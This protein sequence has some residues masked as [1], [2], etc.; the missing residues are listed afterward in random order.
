MYGRP[1]K[2]SP[3]LDDT[4]DEIRGALFLNKA[5]RA[6]MFR[7][8]IA[9]LSIAYKSHKNGKYLGVIDPKNKTQERILFPWMESC[10]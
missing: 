10:K 4:L 1:L 8:G 9:L 5:S 7:Y 2:I 6:D 3:E